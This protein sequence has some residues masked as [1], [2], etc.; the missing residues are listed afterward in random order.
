MTCEALSG[1]GVALVPYG[2]GHDEATVA[3]LNTPAIRRDFGIA[4]PV[5]LEGHRRWRA[6]QVGL[7]MWA[8]EAPE[9][10]HQGNLLLWPDPR[11]DAAYLQL[12]LGPAAARGRGLGWRALACALDHAFAGLGLHR[13]WLHTLPHNDAAARLYRKAG[14][15]REG[16]ERGAL[17]REDGYLDQHRWSLLAPEWQARREETRP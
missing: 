5:S 8:I 1:Q 14:F 16:V 13:V 10:G 17:R 4:R 3:W 9:G 12:Y 7:L 11:H 2:V 6:Q 15:V